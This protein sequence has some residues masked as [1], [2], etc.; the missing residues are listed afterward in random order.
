MITW[1][2][3]K[4]AIGQQNGNI[5]NVVECPGG[6]SLMWCP[7]KGYINNCDGCQFN[8]KE[9]EIRSDPNNYQKWLK[10]HNKNN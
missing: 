6:Y 1:N 4:C 9:K 7:E 2:D 8:E 3:F 5:E 10:L